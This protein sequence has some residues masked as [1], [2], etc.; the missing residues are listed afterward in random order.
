MSEFVGSEFERISILTKDGTGETVFGGSVD[1]FAS[2]FVIVILVHKDGND[3]TK[4]F[5]DHG[6]G[7]WVF[8]DNDS[9]LDKVSLR[10]VTCTTDENLS[11]FLLCLFDQTCN[12]LESRLVDD[13]TGKVRKVREWTDL[14]LSS[15][16]SEFISESTFP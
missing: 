7:F 2:L 5:L 10:V 14:D 4:D 9:G 3:W 15:L 16:F 13:W 12:L 8:G 11:T 1:Q 6:D